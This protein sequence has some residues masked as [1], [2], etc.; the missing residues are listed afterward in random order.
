MALIINVGIS[1]ILCEIVI[2]VHGHE[3]DKVHLLQ[4]NHLKLTTWLKGIHFERFLEKKVISLN[5]F[6][7]LNHVMTQHFMK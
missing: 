5:K 1:R 3:Q 4:F 7:L 6:N 2:L